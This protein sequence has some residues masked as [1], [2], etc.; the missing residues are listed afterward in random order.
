MTIGESETD[1]KAI[2]DEG[3]LTRWSRRKHEANADPADPVIG[4][5]ALAIPV[6]LEEA[7]EDLPEDSDMPALE[8]LD[9]DS[10]YSGFMSP[11]VSEGL[12]TL[13]LRQLFRG[14]MFNIRDGLDDYDDDFTQ[15]AKLGDVVTAEMRR[16][17]ARLKDV[18]DEELVEASD[19]DQDS[20]TDVYEEP[21]SEDISELSIDVEAS[22]GPDEQLVEK[23]QFNGKEDSGENLYANNDR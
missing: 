3:L 23:E 21:P 11:K 9:E 4:M 17:I 16:Q 18:N 6:V 5:E 7:E 10:D 12:R 22:T 8:T 20:V 13:A 19:D 2:E 1:K 15:F 14:S